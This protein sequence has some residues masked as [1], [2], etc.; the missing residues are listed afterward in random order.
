[1]RTDWFLPGPA[2]LFCPGTRPE[3]FA[4]AA[5]AADMVIVDLEDAVAP[6]DKPAARS[7]VVRA[8]ED[9]RL[10][11]STTIVR[12]NAL[13]TPWGE[14]DLAA[15]RVAE[16]PTIMLPKTAH[17]LEEDMFADLA[18]VALCETAAG[19]ATAPAVAASTPC[20]AI[21]WGGQD[22]AAQLGAPPLTA[23][24]HLHPTGAHARLTVRFAAA[25]AG[26]PAIDTVRTDLQDDDGLASESRAAAG[27]GFLAKLAIHPRQVPVIREA[28]APTVDEL[29]WARRVDAAAREADRGVA[30]IDGEMIDTPVLTRARHLLARA[31][32]AA[33]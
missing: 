20:V 22:L 30:V 23:D 5:A 14:Q 21:A 6:S 1:M 15:L 3:R 24:G 8:L 26:I 28:F 16:T 10:K 33:T 25:A 4:K 9:G 32:S 7:E 29:A 31:G 27:H 2:L 17:A 18:V 19:V 12:I 13:D 11:P